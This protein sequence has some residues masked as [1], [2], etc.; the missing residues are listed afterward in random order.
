MIRL[1]FTLALAVGVVVSISAGGRAQ[2]VV[3]APYGVHGPRFEGYPITIEP[4]D[5]LRY[6]RSYF[7]P[8]ARAGKPLLCEGGGWVWTGGWGL[9]DQGWGYF[10]P[11]PDYVYVPQHCW[12]EPS[13]RR[14]R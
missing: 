8:H 4:P 11:T 5:Y 2:N 1:V 6:S 7:V 12:V 10:P 3:I 13:V 14:R 9:L